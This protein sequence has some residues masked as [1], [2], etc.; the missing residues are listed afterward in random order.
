MSKLIVPP[1]IPGKNSSWSKVRNVG[2]GS[3]PRPGGSPPTDGCG[4]LC[5]AT[6]EPAPL[7]PSHG[8][9]STIAFPVVDWSLVLC[10]T[11][12]C[13]FA[14]GFLQRKNA[15]AKFYYYVWHS[16]GYL[17][18]VFWLIRCS[19]SFCITCKRSISLEFIVS[20][21]TFLSLSAATIQPHRR[22]Y[23]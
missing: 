23:N 2:K 20:R 1:S 12:Y 14:K 16:T 13:S 11:W 21:S 9:A 17:A 4:W 22:N 19:A 18:V 5:H 8:I 7:P 10:Q 6:A 15:F 3:S